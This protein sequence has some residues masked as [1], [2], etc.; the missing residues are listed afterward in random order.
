MPTPLILA[1]SSPA[2]RAL[3][4]K[5]QLQFEVFKPNID[6]TQLAGET[7]EALVFRLSQQ[8]TQAI[9]KQQPN[10]VGL[11]I[12]SDQVALVDRMV[13]TKPHTHKNA[14]KQLKLCSGKTVLF[15]TGLTLL[16]TKTGKIQ[17]IVDQTEVVFR[18]LNDKQIERYLH[19]DTPYQ[20]AGGFKSEGL[21]ITLF[22][23]INTRDSNALIG[24]PLMAL[25]DM[26][27]VEGVEIL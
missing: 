6:E 7:S 13:L 25:I 19:K 4:I 10:F 9:A 22:E 14:L 11:I 23:R 3:L 2:R 21:G 5:L 1:S 12:G 15:L 16:N 17:T 18:V 27:L 26:L 8:K 24:L 20:C